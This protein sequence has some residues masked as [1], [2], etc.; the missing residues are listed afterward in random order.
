[1]KEASFSKILSSDLRRSDSKFNQEAFWSNRRRSWLEKALNLKRVT[2]NEIATKYASLM[3]EFVAEET[4][5]DP[6]KEEEALAK[7]HL[8]YGPARAASFDGEHFH[9]ETFAAVRDALCDATD[10]RLSAKAINNWPEVQRPIERYL[11]NIVERFPFRDMQDYLTARAE[12]VRLAILTERDANHFPDV[13]AGLRKA[14]I[15]MANN[16]MLTTAQL[17]NATNQAVLTGIVSPEEARSLSSLQNDKT[18]D[19]N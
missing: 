9:P 13:R 7:W 5:G 10:G 8:F 2:K 1:M 15:S 18:A 11:A 12:L 16:S 14:L 19:N 3:E 6:G 4:A 17:Q